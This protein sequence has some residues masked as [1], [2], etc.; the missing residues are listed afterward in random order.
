MPSRAGER[1]GLEVRP[2]DPGAVVPVRDRLQRPHHV[3]S[4]DVI[5][6]GRYGRDARLEERLSG[7][8]EALG[9]RTEEVD[10]G[11]AVHL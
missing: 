2:Q 9:V 1:K 11:E 6:V 8:G 5:S 7:G 10:A 4:A 3:L